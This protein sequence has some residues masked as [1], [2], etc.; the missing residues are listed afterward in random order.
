MKK[1]LYCT[2]SPFSPRWGILRARRLSRYFTTRRKCN[3]LPSL[4]GGTTPQRH[5]TDV[6]HK[7]QSYE[8]CMCPALAPTPH[9]ATFPCFLC[10]VYAG[11]TPVCQAAMSGQAELLMTM[12]NS[13]QACRKNRCVLKLFGKSLEEGKTRVKG[14]D[15]CFS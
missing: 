11:V 9:S 13:N 7:L 6:L 10:C 12:A 8:N 15:V 1:A 2:I 4:D 5:L 3:S 14:K